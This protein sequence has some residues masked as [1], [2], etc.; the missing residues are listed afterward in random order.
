MFWKGTLLLEPREKP[1]RSHHPLLYT[2]PLTDTNLYSFLPPCHF[3]SVPNFFPLSLYLAPYFCISLLFLYSF[4]SF[5]SSPLVR[6]SAALSVLFN[7]TPLIAL[8]IQCKWGRSRKVQCEVRCISVS[9][10]CIHLWIHIQVNT[11][12]T[13]HLVCVNTLDP[14]EQTVVCVFAICKAH[15]FA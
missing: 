2:S 7:W 15:T 1:A 6:L 11:H 14:H 3:F 5:Y 10:E 13:Q 4:L 9:A 8:L 12:V